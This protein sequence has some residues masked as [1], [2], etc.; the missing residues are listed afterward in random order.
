MKTEDKLGIK[1][2]STAQI[3]FDK[4]KVPKENLLGDFEKGLKKRENQKI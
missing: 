2:S 1:G 3:A 4:V